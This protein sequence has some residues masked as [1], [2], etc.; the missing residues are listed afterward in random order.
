MNTDCSGFFSKFKLSWQICLC[1]LI[2]RPN[3][4]K[5]SNPPKMK[6]PLNTCIR[7]IVFWNEC[8]NSVF[9]T[10]WAQFEV[11]GVKSKVFSKIGQIREGISENLN[12]MRISHGW[13]YWRCKLKTILIKHHPI[14]SWHLQ[15]PT[16]FDTQISINDGKIIKGIVFTSKQ[17]VIWVIPR[18]RC[19][20]FLISL[21]CTTFCLNSNNSFMHKS[22]HCV[23]MPFIVV[24][25]ANYEQK[26][27]ESTIVLQAYVNISVEY[28]W[29]FIQTLLLHSYV[30][31]LM[32]DF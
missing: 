8:L 6:N 7:F 32:T 26:L 13:R 2:F 14:L 11:F 17:W 27:L 16:C 18:K 1:C 25:F 10:F 28:I 20:V 23:L 22:I 31:I 30:Y 5:L 3:F 12:C 19:T 9:R 21:V 15:L 29:D 24:L 4:P